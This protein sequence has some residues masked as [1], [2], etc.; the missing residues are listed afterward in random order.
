MQVSYLHVQIH[1]KLKLSFPAGSHVQAA[2]PLLTALEGT[3]TPTGH[4]EQPFPPNIYSFCVC[5]AGTDHLWTQ[6]LQHQVCSLV[7]CTRISPA[8]L[9]GSPCLL[10]WD[11]C[12]GS[13][14]P[15]KEGQQFAGQPTLPG[16]SCTMPSTSRYPESSSVLLPHTSIIPG[17]SHPPSLP[18][19]L[20]SA[21]TESQRLQTLLQ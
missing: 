14:E 21:L 2:S 13:Q 9:E 17:T 11:H 3:E 20:P 6:I 1:S 19:A 18:C 10:L 4:S 8:H 16:Q 12:C 15:R 5:P 7:S